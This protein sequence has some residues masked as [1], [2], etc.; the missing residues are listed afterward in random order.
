[1]NKSFFKPVM[2]VFVFVAIFGVFS[3]VHSAEREA[4]KLCVYTLV[5]M[6]KL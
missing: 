3:F 2:E 6:G 5:E 4:L 1:M